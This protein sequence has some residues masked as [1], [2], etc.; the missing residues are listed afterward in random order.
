MQL[1]S[2]IA[3]AVVSAGSCSSNSIPSLGTSICYRCIRKKK[4]SKE[5]YDTLL[6]NLCLGISIYF[7]HIPFLTHWH[8][9]L[10][11]IH[12][13]NPSHFAYSV[14]GQISPQQ[15]HSATGFPRP[16]GLELEEA[17]HSARGHSLQPRGHQDL[18]GFASHVLFFLSRKFHRN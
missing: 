16:S 17:L 14:L 13:T 11:C 2:G 5:I 7:T 1:E 4:K 10:N 15:N 9:E 3:V 18:K 6:A 8:H 12:P